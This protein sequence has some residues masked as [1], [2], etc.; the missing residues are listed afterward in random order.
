[1][2]R[3]RQGFT[4][5]EL[6]VV[7]GIIAVLIAMLLPALNRVRQQAASTQ[8]QSNL[9]ASG[10]ILFMYANENHGFLP[11]CVVNSVAK[12]PNGGTWVDYPASA[13]DPA[14]AYPAVR[15]ILDRMVNG[16]RSGPDGKQVAL[17]DPNWTPGGLKIF[18]CP[19]SWTFAQTPDHTAET[20][21][22]GPGG[23]GGGY[24]NYWYVGCPN[25][26][27]PRFHA[28]GPYPT[29]WFPVGGG[30]GAGTLDWR[31]WDRN[32]SGDNR[33]DYMVKLGDKNAI[34]IVIMVDAGRQVGAN[35]NA[36]GFSF[37][38]GHFSSTRLTGW[39]NALYGDGHVGSRK[40]NSSSWDAAQQNFI[41][42][43]PSPEEL[44]PGWGNAT[45]PIFW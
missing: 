1:M 8:C 18:Y 16:K 44:Q 27:Y 23:V 11:P 3:K 37:M 43:T 25:P 17:T 36:Y 40:V 34:N 24:L 32:R 26:W 10:Q 35:A 14:P 39:L 5:V 41:N 7:I 15:E 42:P 12:I 6:L 21:N 28:A 13:Q 38:H 45:A 29:P 4:L 2:Q 20:F 33:D 31:W 19:S 9:R 22:I 30:T